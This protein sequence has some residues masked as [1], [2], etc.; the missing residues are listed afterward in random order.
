MNDRAR[1]RQVLAFGS[2]GLVALGLVVLG[3]DVLAEESAVTGWLALVPGALGLVVAAAWGAIDAA[4]DQVPDVLE[5]EPVDPGDD[6]G[7]HAMR[8]QKRLAWIGAGALAALALQAIIPLTYYLGDDHYDE[9]FSWRMFSAVR[10]HACDLRA[11]E[12]RAGVEQ[13]VNLMR[14]VQA[15][16]V[17]TLE[18]NREAVMERYLRWRCGQAGTERARLVNQCR[19][20]DGTAVPPIVRAIDCAS[21]AITREGGLE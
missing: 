1:T 19:T 11:F 5:R 12:V 7:V 13:P 10:M 4:R 20:P 14:T 18:R 2:A 8:E 16:W 9:R 3:A 6:P 21:G 15:G 17:T